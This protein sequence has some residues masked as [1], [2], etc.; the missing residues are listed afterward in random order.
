MKKE[1]IIKN[2][3]MQILEPVFEWLKEHEDTLDLLNLKLYDI[4][5]DSTTSSYP[6]VIEK[7][8]D[9]YFQ[10][11]C[12]QEYDRLC[13]E[14]D[15]QN[16]KIQVGRTSSFY[17]FDREYGKVVEL[18]KRNPINIDYLELLC[19]ALIA[20]LLEDNRLMIIEHGYLPSWRAKWDKEDCEA[21]E[22]AMCDIFATWEN[23]F[24]SRLETYKYIMDFK[25]HQLDYW[26]DFLEDELKNLTSWTIKKR[27]DC[28]ITGS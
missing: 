2:L 20:D 12:D 25:K 27:I 21:W 15:F 16:Q 19:N 11:F 24:K 17:L 1:T 26:N 10:K 5:Y 13:D 7:N 8:Y 23:V 22:Y 28:R 3:K 18:L 4:A 14:T 9:Q 6:A